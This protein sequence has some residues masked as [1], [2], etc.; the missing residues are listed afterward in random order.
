MF[1]RALILLLIAGSLAGAFAVLQP[2][3]VNASL[4]AETYCNVSNGISD[5][6]HTACIA[7][8]DG[9]HACNQMDN[10]PATHAC[11]QGKKNHADNPTPPPTGGSVADQ[12]CGG[13]VTAANQNS[14]I[15]KCHDGVNQCI[16]ANSTNQTAQKDCIKKVNGV[17]QSKVDGAQ[18]TT[19]PVDKGEE[20]C[21][22]VNELARP[23]C[24]AGYYNGFNCDTMDPGPT[25]D[26]C[27]A[28]TL[29]C[30]QLGAGASDACQKGC[31]TTGSKTGVC[32]PPPPGRD[33]NKGVTCAIEKMGWMLCPI[34]ETVNKISDGAFSL[35]ANNFLQVE[36]KLYNDSNT[37]TFAAWSTF[38][39][40][41][42]ILFVI[43]FLI[44]IY[45]QITG[46]GMSNYGLK[47]MLP[48]LIIAAILV[49]TSYYVCQVIVDLTNIGGFE[50]KEVL[51]DIANGLLQNSKS[52]YASV[53][54]SG[55]LPLTLI[56]AGILGAAAVW[57]MLP[58]LFGIAIS[59]MI[60]LLVIIIIL[61]LRK[62]FIVLLIVISPIAFVAYL[63]PNT[64]DLFKKWR[65]MFID[66]L[67]VFP[68]I[69]LLFGGGQ[70]ASAIILTSGLNYSATASK[71]ALD[72][73]ETSGGDKID[74]K[75]ES[76]LVQ[77]LVATAIAVIPLFAVWGVLKAAL[78]A[79]S[80]INGMIS[81]L[82]KRAS[83]A[84]RKF[85]S[86]LN[87][88]SAASRGR[89]IRANIKKNYKSKK[90]VKRLGED[91]L[92]GKYT[93]LAYKGVGA[94]Y[95]PKQLQ[96]GGMK[97]V[98]ARVD[99]LALVAAKKID[100]EEI[101][102]RQA[103]MIEQGMGFEQL[104]TLLNNTLSAGMSDSAKLSVKAAASMMLSRGAAG[105]DSFSAVMAQ[106]EDAN[107]GMIDSKDY[108][109]FRS[110][111]LEKH[112]NVDSQSASTFGWMADTGMKDGEFVGHTKMSGHQSDPGNFDWLSDNE[113]A[114][115]T[116]G[117]MEYLRKAV[118]ADGTRSL[119]PAGA[120]R[121]LNSKAASKLGTSQ[122]ASL[123]KIASGN[124]R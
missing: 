56:T 66:L 32:T 91:S 70:L 29:T 42:N 15:G 116:P 13:K 10:G 11:E 58:L 124:F 72:S 111:A 97:A 121:I 108:N 114:S 67:L 103:E 105:V 61:L 93:N 88:R 21:K 101:K 123:E 120:T 12:V 46:M 39:D 44:L 51:K 74:N 54:S 92:V 107:P 52:P 86:G 55:N 5:A 19:P 118:G 17:D 3:R 16:S 27:K 60:A 75:T 84:G 1:R 115:Q 112:G 8:Y 94:S 79:G 37:G 18:A 109:E 53:M 90:V 23:G 36:P 14:T 45:S 95:L 48:R 71:N 6:V 89:A 98:N 119:S 38:R 9:T 2:T 99:R 7:G 122:R 76:S 81:G 83:S 117:S 49:N 43:A 59:V 63:L 34:I 78:S 106:I 104:A 62:A 33:P 73:T 85:G 50:I 69:S 110:Y 102:E 31:D 64:E 96:T 68:I 28:G 25:K 82:D 100:D 26:A 24:Y 57:V 80:T 65:K 113:I 30:S 35:L 87:E 47:K 22:N 41:A 20:A 77:G 4:A 40:L